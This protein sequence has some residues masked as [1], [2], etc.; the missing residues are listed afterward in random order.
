MTT[1]KYPTS[2]P[3]RYRIWN[4]ALAARFFKEEMA[5]RNVH[6][7]I[8]QEL[9]TE[10]GQGLS[11]AGDFRFA[12][13][14]FPQ[15]GTFNG[16]QVCA[17]AIGEFRRWKT[18]RSGFPPYIAYLC[19]FVLAGGTDGD[20]A[21]N[22]YYPRLWTLMGYNARTGSVPQFDHM[23]DLWDD[24]EDWSVFDKQ[25][26]LGIF[27]SRSI[28]GFIHVGY[29]LSQSLLAEQER[30]GL[31]QIF[32]DAGLE[33]AGDYPADE[34]A[35]TL[36]RPLARQT[37]R[38]RTVRLVENQQYPDLY[39]A[40]L[41]AV[42]EELSAWDGTVSASA[43]G[44][45]V[46]QDMRALA[47]L[48][49]CIDLDHVSNTVNASIRCKL[50]R[51]FPDDGLYIADGLEAGESGNGWSLPIRKRS[52]G[53]ILDAGQ[54]DWNNGSTMRET[55]LGLQLKLPGRD[56]R[57]FT[58]GIQEGVSGFVETHMVP[59]EQPFYL[60]YSEA[61]WPRLERWATM[62]C[63][64]FQEIAIAH[65]LPD[66]WRL[67]GVESAI[68]D[69]AVR[70]EF[71]ML[72]FKSGTRLKLIGGIRSRAG[73]NFFHFAPPSVSLSGGT[74]NTEVYWGD[75]ALSRSEG[76][77]IFALPGDLPTES[78]ISLE[79]RAN[80]P[81]DHLSLFL[82][83]DFSVA[84]FEPGF[85]LGPTGTSTSSGKDEPFIAGAC[86]SGIDNG[87]FTTIAEMLEDFSY[88][89]GAEQ[90]YLIGW[91]P[92]QIATWP[93]EAFPTGWVPA[94]AI[95]K[96]GRKLTAIFTDEALG[97]LQPE[98]PSFT[99]T[100]RE[101]QEWKKVIWHQRKRITPPLDQRQRVLWLQL[102]GSARNV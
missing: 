87:A 71:T 12:V 94:W 59:R 96:Q 89:I 102:Q 15:A 64:G 45:S 7:Y 29:P 69:E 93:R 25:G 32:Y 75:L 39:N 49:I 30:K 56:V 1:T 23:R 26:E 78:R 44:H 83:G 46:P 79:A 97:T 41:D 4:D 54:I 21:P 48:R 92:G 5:G 70:D 52:T 51:E 82:T 76:D 60:A 34:L 36:R 14:G 19:L 31:P 2:A 3:N 17:R 43:L 88:E 81:E 50:N 61:V 27:R 22:A 6:L 65:G 77:R 80:G 98:L 37:L 55:V 85:F 67:A 35:R 8:N 47:G 72:S 58:S 84:Q 74:P 63:H 91:R 42:A 68:S 33:P 28:G 18:V 100:H 20:F 86:L 95:K 11:D 40:L 38:A 90:G 24:L 53:E 62:E 101:I 99:P 16:E 9:V 66:G 57:V 73:N 10:I 13:G